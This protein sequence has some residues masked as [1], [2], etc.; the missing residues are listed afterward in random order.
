M[1]K[2]LKI[3]SL[4]LA[5]GAGMAVGVKVYK[6][7][8]NAPTPAATGQEEKESTAT[9]IDV[10][11]LRQEVLPSSGFKVKLPWKDMGRRLVAIGVIDRSKFDKL[12]ADQKDLL[13]Y[14]ER[15]DTEE[16]TINSQTAQ[17][18]VDALWALGLANK[19]EVLDKGPMMTG[20]QAGNFAS[21]G[22]WTIGKKPAMTYYSKH[23]LIPLTIEQQRRVREV[24]D[25]IYR[26]CCGNSAAFPD[27]NHGM[28]ALAVVEMMVAQGKGDDEIYDTVLK[29]NSFWFTQTYIDLA[30]YFQKH[31]TA[32]REVDPKLLLS[33][34]YSSAGGYTKIRKEIG[35]VP[36]LRSVGGGSCGA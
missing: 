31:G 29:F 32:W 6:L 30:Y 28:A 19:S 2:R 35:D 22:G 26:P 15:T 36:E 4:I 5:L 1:V 18:W 9:K 24:A 27:C 13:Q 14:L 34:D 23:V 12:F 11:K 21:T 25:N 3:L 20:G 33:R 16:I 7:S 10:D 17:F 8:K